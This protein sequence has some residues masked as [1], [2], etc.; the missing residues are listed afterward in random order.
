MKSLLSNLITCLVLLI[1][2]TSGLR[3]CHNIVLSTRLYGTKSSCGGGSS[4]IDAVA[5]F[6]RFWSKDPQVSQRVYHRDF[7]YSCGA[8][9]GLG[10]RSEVPAAGVDIVALPTAAALTASTDAAP[11]A[12]YAV[13]FADAWTVLQK[14][15]S[16]LALLLA[17]EWSLQERSQYQQYIHLLPGPAELGTPMHWPPA[18]LQSFP[19]NALRLATQQQ[20]RRWK[21]LY[22]SITAANSRLTGAFSYEVKY[23]EL[24]HHSNHFSMP[25]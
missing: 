22:D 16:R 18:V 17:H 5:S 4:S 14:P 7:E 6:E 3:V 8:I 13:A 12:E 10:C 19:Y 24:I 21:Q 15:S 2:C 1:P 9:R 20:K 23:E 11:P 25:F